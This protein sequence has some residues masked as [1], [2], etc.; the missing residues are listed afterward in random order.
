M[1]SSKPE[2]NLQSTQAF[3]ICA[4]TAKDAVLMTEALSRENLHAELF[5]R[6]EDLVLAVGPEAIGLII[7]QEALLPTG[8]DML[9][10]RL[11]EQPPWSDL[12]IILLTMGGPQASA[13]GSRLIALLG[14]M[15]NI[16][17][18]E[19][20]IRIQTL[21]STARSAQRAR[22]RQY[23]L[24]DLLVQKERNADELKY[25]RDTLENRIKERTADLKAANVNLRALSAQLIQ[26]R[27]QEGRRIAR[28]LHDSVGQ[29]ISAIAMN[30]SLVKSQSHKLDEAGNRAVAENEHLIAEVTK[31]IR[32]ISYLLHPP[33]LDEL[34]LVS[35]LQIYVDGY[36]RRSNIRVDLTIPTDFGRLS[37]DLE[38]ACFRIVQ[39]CL[40]NVHRHSKSA[41]ARIS[42]RCENDRLLVEISDEGQGMA[43]ERLAKLTSSSGTG[44]GLAGIRERI[45]QLRGTL[46]ITSDSNGTAIV[47]KLPLAHAT[48]AV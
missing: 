46:E 34:G 17:I 22:H 9:N 8:V 7:T 44:V 4:P 47:A 37:S 42:I 30:M 12:P 29:L 35:A 41:V 40:T 18:I 14:N 1:S 5:A 13:A 32:T 3:Y 27:D 48:T 26:S 2:Q 25:A 19:R 38:I 36:S 21:I 23:E 20:P 43:P 11:R 31:E 45:R 24:R 10:C 28:D 33:L 15:G 6:M 16:T 39:E